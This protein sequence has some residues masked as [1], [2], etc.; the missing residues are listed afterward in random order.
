MRAQ[1]E[2]GNIATARND[3]VHLRAPSAGD[4]PLLFALRRDQDLQSLLLTVPEG[5]TDA[6]LEAWV[7]RK[8]S[9]PGEAFLAIEDIATGAAVGY[10]QVTQV[11]R[12]NRTGYGGIVL[13]A[14]ARGRGLGRAALQQLTTF[15]KAQFGLRKLLAEIR[16][17]NLP[18]M[19][20]HLALGYRVVG[21]LE[22][23]F[24]DAHGQQHDVVLL[25]RL[26]DDART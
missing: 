22:K 25:E 3:S 5:T 16:K 12:K 19:N 9:Q 6:D 24:V 18:S 15:G 17:D 7:L 8:R 14:G 10:V 21:T 20:L 11:H 23:H 13:A 2:T 26:L 4:H 1:I